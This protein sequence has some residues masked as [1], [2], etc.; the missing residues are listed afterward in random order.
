MI[1]QATE[2]G[3]VRIEVQYI[4]RFPAWTQS[5]D[6]NSN[7]YHINHNVVVNQSESIHCR[8]KALSLKVIYDD[9]SG[10]SNAD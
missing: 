6:N 1:F 8:T 9:L 10:W 4:W 7:N 5:E 3:I 2:M